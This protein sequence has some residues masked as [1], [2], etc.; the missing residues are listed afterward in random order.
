[1]SDP[2]TL[3]TTLLLPAVAALIVPL[4]GRSGLGRIATMGVMLFVLWLAGSMFLA[5]D[6]A[7]ALPQFAI[8]Q[9]WMPTLGIHLRFAVDGYNA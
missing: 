8:D 7:A 6:G 2:A 5:F 1:M 4:L 9:P 3:A